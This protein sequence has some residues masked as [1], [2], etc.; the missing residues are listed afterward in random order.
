[1]SQKEERE[2]VM[3]ST[4]AI[5]HAN[6]FPWARKKSSNHIRTSHKTNSLLLL[7]LFLMMLTNEATD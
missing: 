7:L 4:P 2:A 1:M 6:W 3:A 5:L